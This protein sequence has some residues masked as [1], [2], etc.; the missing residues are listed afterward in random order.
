MD[1]K[2]IWDNKSSSISNLE[3]NKEL[4]PIVIICSSGLIPK[5]LKIKLKAREISSYYLLASNGELSTRISCEN[6][7]IT[8]IY[9]LYL[10]K[11]PLPV[12]SLYGLLSRVTGKK[13]GQYY[14]RKM[15]RDETEEPTS[16]SCLF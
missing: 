9:I 13:Q 14:D 8:I 5:A 6:K 10:K 2:T 11:P 12:P 7:I 16:S 3:K 1:V 4:F 15:Y